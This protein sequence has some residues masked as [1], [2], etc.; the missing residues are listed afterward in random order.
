MH[1]TDPQPLAWQIVVMGVSGC[2]KTTVATELAQQLHLHMIDGDDLHRPESVAKMR[3]GVALQDEDRW[4][5]LDCIGQTL[6]APDDRGTGRVIA[7]SAL[8]RAY[9]DR[10][11]LHAPQVRFVFLDGSPE[12]IR[13]RMTQR[14]GHYMPP[15]LLQSQLSTLQ[16]PGADETDVVT[17]SLE[18]PVDQLAVQAIAALQSCQPA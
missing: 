9:R 8:K 1:A 13:Q 18:A 17:V 12:T 10:I 3:A 4:P 6:S 7:C 5:W 16:R 11:R 15:E 14:V 2:G